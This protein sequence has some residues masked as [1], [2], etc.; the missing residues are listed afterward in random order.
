MEIPA[1]Y[2]VSRFR[3]VTTRIVRVD[4]SARLLAARRAPIFFD[5]VPAPGAVQLVGGLSTGDPGWSLMAVAN[6]RRSRISLSVIATRNLDVDGDAMEE[7]AYTA[8][9]HDLKPATYQI[10]VHHV[11]RSAPGEG[12]VQDLLVFECRVTVP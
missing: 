11:F 1:L 8:T 10:G 6:R 3:Q 5:V 2:H 9:L 12:A 7:H 4:F